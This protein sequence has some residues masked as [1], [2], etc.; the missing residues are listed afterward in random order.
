MRGGHTR[1]LADNSLD[2]ADRVRRAHSERQ[3]WA[4]RPLQ[5]C[6][7]RHLHCAY[8]AIDVQRQ[9]LSLSVRSFEECLEVCGGDGEARFSE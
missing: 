6:R 7:Q 9:Q 8:L 4:K 2:L 1:N 3:Q 5:G